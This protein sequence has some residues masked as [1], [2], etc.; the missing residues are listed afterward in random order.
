MT[1]A[2]KALCAVAKTKPKAGESFD[3][4]VKRLTDKIS[5]VTDPEWQSLGDG[6]AAQ[7]WHNDAM[8]AL[9]SRKAA[10]AAARK[11]GEDEVAAQAAIALPELDGY[12]AV[13]AEVEDADSPA[14]GSDAEE[15]VDPDTGEVTEK[16]AAKPAKEKKS[17]K[18]KKAK[19]EKKVKPAKV[20]KEKKPKAAKKEGE[21]RG[22]RSLFED[23]EKVK[24]LIKPNPHRE[25]SS[26]FKEYEK[27]LDGKTVEANVEHGVSRQ[28]IWSMLNRKVVSVG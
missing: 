5:N 2:F 23:T 16:K 19:P 7:T 12:E 14:D 4:F 28:Q 26:R 22:R 9:D 25:G 8:T 24:I 21:T 20:A 17:K 6:S 10:K 15:A 13:P 3:D 11:N 27:L 1:T 18:E